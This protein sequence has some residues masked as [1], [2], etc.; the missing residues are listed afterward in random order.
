[1]RAPDPTRRGPRAPRRGAAPPVEPIPDSVLAS[2]SRAATALWVALAVLTL[3]RLALPFT[4]SMWFWGLNL[5]RFLA[6]LPAWGLWGAAAL[7]LVPKAARALAP[8]L[9]RI[10]DEAVGARGAVIAALLAAIL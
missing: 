9:A 1:M 10:G 4:P 7:A 3:A 2:A 5:Q 6:P 8:W